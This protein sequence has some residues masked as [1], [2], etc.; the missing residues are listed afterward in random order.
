MSRVNFFELGSDDPQRAIKFYQ[1]VFGWKAQKYE[2]QQ[3]Y[4]LVTTGPDTEVGING[5]ITRRPFPQPC[6]TTIGVASLD[7][8]MAK[9]T[10]AGGKIL[11]PKM[12]IPMIGYLA[13]CQDTE[14]T[15]FGVI[16]PMPGMRPM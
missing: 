12:E 10:A 2:G 6:V 13:Y 9:I 11:Q 14:G 16:E 15:V 7:E 8:T 3:D 4:Y 5:A 1:D